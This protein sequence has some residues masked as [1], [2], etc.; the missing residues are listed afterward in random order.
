M[1]VFKLAALLQKACVKK[2][3]RP[4]RLLRA[5]LTGCMFVHNNDSIMI[6]VWPYVH[7]MK[8]ARPRRGAVIVIAGPS[9]AGKGTIIRRLMEL[10]PEQV[11]ETAPIVLSHEL[12]T[13]MHGAVIGASDPFNDTCEKALFALYGKA[14]LLFTLDINSANS[15]Y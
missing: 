8:P 13:G 9:G 4:S 7:C 12:L 3:H 14:L 10:F 15:A 1:C 11:D 2:S 6:P 5:R